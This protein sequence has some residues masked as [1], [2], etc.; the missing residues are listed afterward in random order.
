MA[1]SGTADAGI[2]ALFSKARVLLHPAAMKR[3]SA[4][5]AVFRDHGSATLL[6]KLV[7]AVGQG[8]ALASLA[9]LPGCTNDALP[10]DP[11]MRG[12]AMPDDASQRPVLEPYA[13]AD[14]GCW[15]PDHAGPFNFGQCCVT[16]QCYTPS[17]GDDCAAAADRLQS[18]GFPSVTGKCA[19]NVGPGATGLI[20]GPFAP[21]PQDTPASPGE[22][23]YL[24]GAIS[25]TGRPLTVEGRAVIAALE[26][27][28][29]WAPF[30]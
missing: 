8:V 23:C 5:C 28:C 24:T 20:A 4:D 2:R 29:D 21:N 6:E 16:A 1:H 9:V 18:T 22:C 12:D 26:L 15:G 27:R 30:A 11:A 25:C 14:L 13:S 19:C 7:K 3:E 10:T 17:A